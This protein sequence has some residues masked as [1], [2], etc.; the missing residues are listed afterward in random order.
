M[1]EGYKDTPLLKTYHLPV[2]EGHE[3]YVE[4]AGHPQGQPVLFLH[5]GPGGSVSEKSRRF[6][7]PAK[8]HMVLFD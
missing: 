5:G 7:N 2:S 8:Y 1:F 4:E 6:F 3:L